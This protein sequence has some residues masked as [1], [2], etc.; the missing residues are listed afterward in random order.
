MPCQKKETHKKHKNKNPGKPESVD[1]E[2][3]RNKVY[4]YTGQSSPKLMQFA[5]QIIVIH[6]S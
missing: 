2:G 4:R 5:T 1:G 3:E 6:G